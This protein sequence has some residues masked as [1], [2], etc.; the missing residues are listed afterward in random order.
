MNRLLVLAVTSLLASAA[1]VIPQH[2]GSKGRGN[3]GCCTVICQ[4]NDH[5]FVVAYRRDATTPAVI[6]IHKIQFA[7][8]QALQEYK[9]NSGGWFCHIIITRDGWVMTIGG[10]DNPTI[11]KEL[12]N[13]ASN[14]IESGKITKSDLKKAEELIRSNGWGHFVIKSP[15]GNVGV[16]VWDYR[17]GSGRV[18]LFKLQPGWYVKVTNNPGYYAH[19]KWTSISKDPVK[20]AVYIIG[21]DTYG[22]HRR[23]VI[24]YDVNTQG[25]NAKIDVSAAFDGGAMVG[26]APGAPDPIDFMGKWVPAKSLPTIPRLK[27]LGTVQLS[28]PKPVPHPH[29]ERSSPEWPVLIPLGLLAVLALERRA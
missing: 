17:V 29:E 6:H 24:V 27:F 22:I 21:T 14:I 10:R 19:S 3:G 8:R 2:L 7:G 20:A 16:A 28:K 9:N 25:G 5:R 1:P 11:N 12:E 13:L 4:V 18:D 23:D 26:G 15:N